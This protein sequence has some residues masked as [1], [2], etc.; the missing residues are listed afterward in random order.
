MADAITDFINTLMNGKTGGIPNIYII[1]GIAG[2]ALIIYLLVTRKP[3]LKDFKPLDMKKETKRR[4]KREYKY[5]GLPLNKNVYNVNDDEKPIA[6]AIG[7]MPVTEMKEIKRLEPVY[8]GFS[9]PLLDQKHEQM[10]Q[11]IY[12][13]SYKDLN[14]V[15]KKNADEASRDELSK[16]R[17][18]VIP[19]GE[20]I[21]YEHGRKIIDFS[22]PV[23][24][25]ALKICS[26]EILPKLLARFLNYG[27]DWALFNKEQ[28]KQDE[29]K[30]LI[31]GSFQRRQAFD[32]FIFSKEGKNLVEDLSFGV[33]RENIWQETA[34]QI[35][36]AVHFDT[37]ASKALIFRRED[38]KIE[39][40]K[41]KAQTES[42]EFG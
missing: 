9:K 24:M 40:D 23:P 28:L 6:Y 32:V 13:K 35:P 7:Y 38:A 18:Q 2:L 17:V 22:I 33:E 29:D 15:E 16:E 10:A 5:F 30:I 31:T 14:E 42:H 36:R 25:Y 12:L 41:R 26:P 39:K 8:T 37:E 20:K 21:K 34:N 1:I 19:K 3:R 4:F 27:I 11:Q